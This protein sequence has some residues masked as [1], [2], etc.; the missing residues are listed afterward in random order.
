M[1][2][3]WVPALR[4]T[5]VMTF[6]TGMLYPALTTGL[7]QLLFP[8]QANGSFVRKDGRVIG[9]LLIGQQFSRPEYFHPRPSAAGQGY[10]PAASGG[11]NLGPTSAQLIGRVRKA[12]ADYRRE[13]PGFRGPV[14]PDSVTASASGLDPHITPANA[15]AQIPRVAAA[16]SVEPARIGGLVRRIVEPREW[17]FLGEPR[18][19]VLRLNL[20]LDAQYPLRR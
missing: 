7:A 4:L 19:N 9:S 11:S 14:P 5:I 15:E 1:W 10:D 18:V 16:R 17:S 12:V 8:R 6:L 2:Q 13:N 3:E 20:A